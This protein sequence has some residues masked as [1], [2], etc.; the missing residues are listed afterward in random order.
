MRFPLGVIS[1]SVALIGLEV[2]VTSPQT[3]RIAA[4]FALP[5]TLARDLI[6]PNIPGVPNKAKPATPTVPGTAPGDK[7]TPGNTAPAVPAPSTNPPRSA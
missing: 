7:S 6:D 4:L 3:G 2:L 5:A 1:G